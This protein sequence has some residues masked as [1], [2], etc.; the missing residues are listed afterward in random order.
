M[1]M[2]AEVVDAPQI[3]EKYDSETHLIRTPDQRLRVFVS[4]TLQ[5]LAVERKIVRQAIEHLCLSPVMFELGARPHPAK[6]LYRAYLKQSHIFLGIYWQR[7]G[8]VAPNMTVSGLEDE[9]YLSSDMPRLIYIKDP[10]AER[11]PRLKQMLDRIT[12]DNI[13]FKFFNTSDELRE[14]VKNDLIMILTERFELSVSAVAAQIETP[15]PLGH[16]LPTPPTPLIGRENEL[17]ALHGLLRREDP[18]L[19]TLTGPGGTGKSR[20]AW[21]LAQEL[22]DRF[23]DGVYLVELASIQHPDLVTQAIAHTLGLREEHERQ[24]INMMLLS[25]LRDKQ[26][27]LV[28][29]NFEHVLDAA[30]VVAG[31]LQNCPK[32]RILVTSRAP[33]KLRAE[34][35]FPVDPLALPKAKRMNELE[36]ITQSPAVQL[37]IQRTLDVKPDFELRSDNALAVAE[38]CFRLDGLPLAIELA[39]ARSKLLS[40]Q[41]MLSR[42]ETHMP[43]LVGGMRDLPE[44]QRTL[45]ATIEWSHYLLDEPTKLLFRRLAVFANSWTID[46]VET[47][48]NPNDDLGADLLDTLE[49]LVDNSLI[50]QSES[51]DG[52]VRFKML[53]TIHEFS[54]ERLNLSDEID[55]IRQRHAQFYLELVEAMLPYQFKRLPEGWIIRINAEFEN[56]R[57]AINWSYENASDPEMILRLVNASAWF[58]F[59]SGQLSE[60]YRWCKDA[61]AR[62]EAIG[63]TLLRGKAYV[64]AGG[65]GFTI[66]KYAEAGA[67]LEQSIAIARQFGDQHLLAIGLTY[68]ALVL[69]G[70]G[71]YKTSIGVCSESIDLAKR[72]QFDWMQIL[73]L[74]AMGDNHLVL[75]GIE[76][77]R[78]WYEDSYHLALQMGDSWLLSL[79][80][81]TLAFIYTF[82]GDYDKALP[83]FEE[84]IGLMR[85]AGDRWGLAY[86]LASNAYFMLRQGKLD[87]ARQMLD[88]S[89]TL[90]CG[91]ASTTGITI[92]LIGYAGLATAEGD[93]QRAARLFGA[94]DGLL[95]SLNVQS[96]PTENVMHN[97]YL[98]ITRAQLDESVYDKCYAEGHGMQQ[99]EVVAY[100]QRNK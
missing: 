93:P 64:W 1:S 36:L 37:F 59:L 9:Y 43:L 10:A 47:I 50:R 42:L 70:L 48:C 73:A 18:G 79:S 83:L 16:N 5:E 78:P 82:A 72:M 14:A 26:L 90:A 29:D 11:E 28:L 66:G 99:D 4:S 20:L 67:D 44:R 61:L 87:E 19:I 34:Q 94:A 33:L 100:T 65:L 91:V 63:P 52:E 17:A 32:L 41:A 53:E 88:E 89:L 35:E 77:A 21:Q 86:V 84:S 97:A 76:A 12:N 2:E 8:W 51:T 55:L 71:E 22:V 23:A 6:E 54:W 31:L 81:R 98:A 46:A 15:S 49:A 30:P 45:T 24:S 75:G 58:C 60:G 13:S 95:E 39:A 69:T 38:I 25:T 80:E 57:T 7:Y 96:G 56:L 92:A 68:D 27:L 85:S 74:R 3:L 62:T 40:P